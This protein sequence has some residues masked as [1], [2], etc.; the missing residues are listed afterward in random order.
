MLP[1]HVEQA[2]PGQPAQPD[3]DGNRGPAQVGLDLAGGYLARETLD[4][5]DFWFVPSA[6]APPMPQAALLLPNYDEYTVAYK[7]RGHFYDAVDFSTAA[8]RDSAPFANMVMLRG[9]VA[10][11]W[12]RV[13]AKNVVEVTTRLLRPPSA[14]EQQA[15]EAAS[16]RYGEYLGLPVRQA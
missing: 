3:V 16:K 4:G 5:K 1:L 15:L 6:P 14:A 10:G 11:I 13:L 2:F 12:K 8:V 7:D 9:R